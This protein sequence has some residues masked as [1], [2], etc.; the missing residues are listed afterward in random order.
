MGDSDLSAFGRAIRHHRQRLS[1]SQEALAE[2]SG[3]HFT[4][5]SGIERGR[6]NVGVRNVYRLADG[7]G[8]TAAQLFVT[9]E[10]YRRRSPRAARAT[11][12][13]R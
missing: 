1:L 11:R 13:E 6:R 4:Y 7:L 8:L 10:P 3:L 5:V 12:D 9:A 2:R